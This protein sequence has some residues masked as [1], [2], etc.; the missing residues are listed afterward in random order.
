MGFFDGFSS[1]PEADSAA[2][3]KRDDKADFWLR[4][5]AFTRRRPGRAA[6]SARKWQSVEDLLER[7]WRRFG[8]FAGSALVVF[9]RSVQFI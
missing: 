3:Q 2:S 9:A 8:I 7:R 6:G 4:E 5:A 1:R